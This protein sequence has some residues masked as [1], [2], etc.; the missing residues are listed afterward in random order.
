MPEWWMPNHDIVLMELAL[1]HGDKW[2]RY[3]KEL[4]G[5]N[6]S[7]YMM[8]LL[9]Q[10]IEEEHQGIYVPGHYSF[11]APDYNESEEDHEVQDTQRPYFKFQHWCG[12]KSHILH[13]LKYITNTIM[14]KLMDIH[15]SLVDLRIPEKNDQ[16]RFSTRSCIFSEYERTKHL[17]YL[18]RETRLQKVT[19]KTTQLTLNA[20]ETLCAETHKDNKMQQEIQ[21][22]RELANTLHTSTAGAQT[23][24]DNDAEQE[25]S[26]EDEEREL[27]MYESDEDETEIRFHDPFM[28]R[29]FLSE[30]KDVIHFFDILKYG[31]FMARFILNEIR[32]CNVPEL[33]DILSV[34]MEAMPFPM[35]LRILNEQMRDLRRSKPERLFKLCNEMVD[36]TNFGVAAALRMAEYFRK[37]SKTDIFQET[38]WRTKSI[39]FEKKAHELINDIES[40]H[41]LYILLTIPLYDTNDAMSI[42]SLA[43]KQ[44]RV[45]FLNN[46]RI[47]GIMKHVWYHSAAIYVEEDIKPRDFGWGEW[48]QILFF[49]PFKFYMSP[50]GF[51]WTIAMFYVLYLVFVASWSYLIVKGD[52]PYEGWIIF[53][54]CN[55]GFV[56]YELSEFADKGTQYFSVNAIMNV[57]DIII[58]IIWVILFL[59]FT[60]ETARQRVLEDHMTIADTATITTAPLEFSN[61]TSTTSYLG[62]LFTTT[63]EEELSTSLFIHDFHGATRQIFSFLWALQLCFVAT[64][65]LTLFQNTRY[66]GSLLKIVQKMFTEIVKFFSVAIVVLAAYTFGFYF[67]FG[68]NLVNINGEEGDPAQDFWPTML[69]T[70]DEFIAGGTAEYTDNHVVPFF[71]ICITVIGFLVLTNMLIALMTTEYEQFRESAILEIAYMSTETCFDLAHRD[72]L[73]PPPFNLFAYA[74]GLLTHIV[75]VLPFAICCGTSYLN[76]Y[77]HFGHSTYQWLN[78]CYCGCN[79]A[80]R[81]AIND[82]IPRSSYVVNDMNERR[83]MFD[84]QSKLI[85]Q[86]RLNTFLSFSGWIFFR[87]CCLS[88]CCKKRIFCCCSNYCDNCCKKKECCG[89]CHWCLKPKKLFRKC[90]CNDYDTAASL[91]TFHKGCYNCISLRIAKDTVTKEDTT[92]ILGISMSHYIERFETHH[93]TKLNKEDKIL[94]KHLTVDTLFCDYCYQPY[95][96]KDVKKVLLSPFRVLLDCISCFI[97]LI[98]AWLPLVIFFSFMTAI[99]YFT[100]NAN[101][102]TRKQ[103]AQM[104]TISLMD[105]LSPI[106]YCVL[107]GVYYMTFILN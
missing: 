89:G 41:L 84:A 99:E 93:R 29:N 18:Q 48:L 98:T 50:A 4:T 56:A 23:N 83:D 77:T 11:I 38:T 44:K 9:A 33:W 15:P 67:I 91:T 32:K 8:R 47:L 52:D 21:L 103:K 65:F 24:G 19:N 71:A 5:D 63:E 17:E 7:N 46:D 43:I 42:L 36:G 76:L 101:N 105:N 26:D 66:L 12:Q 107:P 20:K 97:F 1:K 25:S 64:R 78:T 37:V 10:N 81:K 58:S 39:E 2:H 28:H 3:G 31:P 68:F 69:F 34:I 51:N 86:D 61:M 92:T 70:F 75:F 59:I 35:G 85:Y 100:Q 95:L 6:V 88:S 106:N 87:D 14:H 45:I 72:R 40:D 22:T 94:L 30:L 62:T 79:K 102:Q 57:L 82:A 54:L 74:I 60:T 90:C 13:R 53:W 49:Q 55:A 104:N 80:H 96:E 16:P 27:Y 73:M